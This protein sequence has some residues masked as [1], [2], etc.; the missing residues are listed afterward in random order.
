MKKYE[1]MLV[2]KPNLDSEEADSVLNKINESVESLSG[3]VLETDKM[4]R[5]RLAYDVKNHRD[6]I[7]AVLR[8]ELPPESVKEFNR[9][10]KLNDDV[11]RT[12]FVDISKVKAGV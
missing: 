3:K 1:V 2:I 6:G 4:G 7:F 11:I 9:Q 12:M 8:L 5:R 10:L